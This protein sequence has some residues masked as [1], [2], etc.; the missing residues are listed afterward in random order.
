ML[1]GTKGAATMAAATGTITERRGC[2]N[3]RTGEND[4][5]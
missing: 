4:D 3:V 5:A 2:N 1:A